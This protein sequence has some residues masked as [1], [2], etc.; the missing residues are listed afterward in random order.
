MN[1][2][3]NKMELQEL[4][5]KYS[6]VE[7]DKVLCVLGDLHYSTGVKILEAS[8]T[9]NLH[10]I[11]PQP[12]SWQGTYGQF[13][14]PEDS[15]YLKQVQGFVRSCQPNTAENQKALFALGYSWEL[16][17]SKPSNLEYA[18]LFTNT[19]GLL[20]VSGISGVPQLY[21]FETKTT[22][23]LLPEVP[24]ESETQ[25]E[26]RLATEELEVVTKRLKALKSKGE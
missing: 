17:G 6:M 10:F 20:K 5:K 23:T 15:P 11:E 2:E 22:A 25:R 7:G 12:G 4:I 9:V 13:K 18:F 1:T 3:N 21:S 14:L 19:D 26:I 16:S 8:K 24:V